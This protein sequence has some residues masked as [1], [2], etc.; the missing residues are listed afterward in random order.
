MLI[1][2]GSSA[3]RWTVSYGHVLGRLGPEHGVYA[4][5]GRF[6]TVWCCH[7]DRGTEFTSDEMFKVSRELEMLQLVGRIGVCWDNAMAGS[8]CGRC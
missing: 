5:V 4:A 7:A 2:A 3:R 6:P 8:V 1:P